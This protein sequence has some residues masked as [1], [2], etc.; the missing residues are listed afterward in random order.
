MDRIDAA[1]GALARQQHGV[2]TTVQASSLGM[3]RATIR[4]RLGRGA[5]EHVHDGVLRIS[6]SPP[7]WRQQVMT[8][9]LAAGPGAAA[10]HET[11]GA[12]WG[13]D[14][15]RAGVVQI[16]VPRN[17]HAHLAGVRIFRKRD[18]GRVDLGRVDG[19]PV[20]TPARTLIDLAAIF[21]Y[22]RLQEAVDSAIR[23]GLTSKSR[24]WWRWGQLR[25]RGRNGIRKMGRLLESIDGEP[26]PRSVLERRFMRA[27][28]DLNLPRITA[29][30][31]IKRPDG[32]HVAT[33]DFAAVDLKVAIEVTGHGTHSTRAQRRADAIRRNE[34]EAMG[35]KVFEFTYEQV[36]FEPE[37]VRRVVRRVVL[38]ALRVA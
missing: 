36:C 38:G 4:T 34:L 31:V 26:V 28:A 13:F 22:D 18:L 35:W 15:C 10:C 32:S 20:T 16:T 30:H 7:T 1:I 6:G 29:Q 5:Y 33:V 19:I 17:R 2:F 8:A 24:L 12:L 27:V 23:D 25:R 14:R 21:G 37:Y 11:A 3:T 9:C